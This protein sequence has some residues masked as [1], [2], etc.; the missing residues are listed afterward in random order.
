[1]SLY[2]SVTDLNFFLTLKSILL[3]G[4]FV[5]IFEK[6]NEDD[7]RK[8]VLAQSIIFLIFASGSLL[9]LVGLL[10]K[11]FKP[12]NIKHPKNRN[13][14]EVVLDASST[15]TQ[16]SDFDFVHITIFYIYSR[17]QK[18]KGSFDSFIFHHEIRT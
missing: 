8:G 15:T 10:V 2:I 3:D 14:F 11:M 16:F 7:E 4:E 17:V 18:K 13:F 1:M 12:S 5:L 6:L 9:K